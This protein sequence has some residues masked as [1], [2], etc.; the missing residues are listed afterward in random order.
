LGEKIQI[1]IAFE[2]EEIFRGH[3]VQTPC[4]E[5]GHLQLDQVAQGI[6]YAF[7]YCTAMQNTTQRDS[8]TRQRVEPLLKAAWGKLVLQF[9]VAP[10]F[11]QPSTVHLCATGSLVNTGFW[12][13]PTH[14]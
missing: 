8:R 12:E 7:V 9:Q 3:L 11:R 6:R 13:L 4:S 1:I 14:S 2:L 5:Q 10:G